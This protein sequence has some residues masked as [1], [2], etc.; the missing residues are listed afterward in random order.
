MAQKNTWNEELSVESI[1]AEV[2]AQQSGAEMKLWSMDEIDA[3]LEDDAPTEEKKPVA[4][5]AKEPTKPKP[6]T[7]HLVPHKSMQKPVRE[8]EKP[9]EKPQEIETEDFQMADIP[10]LEEEPKPEPKKTATVASALENYFPNSKEKTEKKEEQAAKPSAGIEEILLQF[11]EAEKPK[12]AAEEPKAEAPKTEVPKAESPKTEEPKNIDLNEEPEMTLEPIA[13]MLEGVTPQP[14]AEAKKIEEEKAPKEET[15]IRGQ[16]SLEKTRLFNEV[17]VHAVYQADVEHHFGQDVKHESTPP[18]ELKKHYHGM[19]TDKNRSRF[20]N[21]PQQELEKTREHLEF[22][23]KLPPK[24]IEKPGVIVQNA[25]EKT[26]VVDGLQAIPTLVTPEDVLEKTRVQE[27]EKQPMPTEEDGVLENQM[28]LDGFVTEEEVNIVDEEEEELHLYERRH[29]KAEKFKLF[30]G[31][32]REG[33]EAD[34]HTE[35]VAD[36]STTTEIAE[37]ETAIEETAEMKSTSKPKRKFKFSSKE[38]KQEVPEKVQVLREYYGPKDKEPVFEIYFAE[39]RAAKIRTIIS[40]IL[41]VAMLISSLMVRATGAFDWVG[42]SAGTYSAAAILFL[43]GLF[44]M[45]FPAYKVGFKALMRKKCTAELGLFVSFL[46]AFLQAAFSFAYAEELSRIPLYAPIA[47]FAYFLYYYAKLQKSKEDI[48]NFD[49]VSKDAYHFYKVK[50]I[51]E[52]EQAS[53]IGRGLLLENP[54]IRYSQRIAFPQNFVET[55]KEKEPLERVFQSVIPMLSFAGAVIG[56]ITGILFQSFFM[57]FSALT[58]TV[59]TAMP[60]STILSSILAKRYLNKQLKKGDALLTSY[61]SA[62]EALGAN[63]VVVDAADLF[64]TSACHLSGMKLYHKMRVDE[65]LLYTAA[66]VIQSSGTLQEVFDNVILKKREI[67]PTVESL[68]YEERLGCSGWIYN[69]RVLVGSRDLLQKHNVEVPLIEEEKHFKKADSE[70][71]YLAVEGKVAAL[72]VVTYAS[73]AQTAAYLQRL[74]KYGVTILVRTSDPNIT[75][76]LLE[77]NFHLPN[78][79]VKILNPVAGKMYRALVKQ[80]PQKELCGILHRR[81]AT[82][83]LKALL[84]AFLCDEKLKIAETLLYIGSGISVAFMAIICFFSGLSQAGNLEILLFQI[85][86]TLLVTQ[87]PKLKKL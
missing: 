19:E 14:E 31:L 1:L 77:Q 84:G 39:K 21:R 55:S 35:Y 5:L 51:D 46:V 20:L 67:L 43:L 2:E 85:L 73:N 22:L 36:E 12:K 69:Q 7:A 58:A 13:P 44:A 4:K 3:L 63:A 60:V 56:V 76:A 65:A 33:I 23:S 74:E 9:I 72:F 50:R 61:A 42:G 28:M 10:I 17:E 66:M 48:E 83:G 11:T 41:T 49:F 82:K 32:S 27:T 57:G 80:E 75:E 47:S 79:L 37:D 40:A 78:N 86:W 81:G 38:E 54:D 30:P 34:E 52:E 71:L 53:E 70:I 29:K 64:N 8:A 24:T 68:A 59:L 62:K 15:D 45:S 6:Q 25:D 26:Q 87:I 16:I 18:E